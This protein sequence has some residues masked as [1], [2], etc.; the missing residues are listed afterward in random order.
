M[1]IRPE[2]RADFENQGVFLTKLNLQMGNMDGPQQQEAVKW[3]A[4]EERKSQRRGQFPIWMDAAL[5]D[6]RSRER[7]NC[8]MADF[9]R[10]AD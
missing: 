6:R 4:E 5:Y 1:S 2:S 7:V 3:L 10:V 9:E 8:G